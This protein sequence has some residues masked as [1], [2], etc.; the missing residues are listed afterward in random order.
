[1]CRPYA[2][3]AAAL[4]LFAWNPACMGSMQ[5]LTAVC[6]D[7]FADYDGTNKSA[8]FAV[9]PRGLYW[10]RLI[11]LTPVERS[12]S[13]KRL[14][15][16]AIYKDVSGGDLCLKLT[17]AQQPAVAPKEPHTLIQG[18]G[19]KC[20]FTERVVKPAGKRRQLRIPL[21]TQ[22]SMIVEMQ[23]AGE[24]GGK[25][26]SIGEVIRGLEKDI[27]IEHIQ[28]VVTNEPAR[29][30]AALTL[31]A[32]DRVPLG[33]SPTFIATWLGKPINGVDESGDKA[34][35][36]STYK[37]ND[38]SLAILHIGNLPA[39]IIRTATASS[40]GAGGRRFEEKAPAS[41]PNIF[42]SLRPSYMQTFEAPMV[43]GDNW[44]QSVEYMFVG[45][46]SDHFRLTL[47]KGRQPELRPQA[48]ME[49]LIDLGGGRFC[50]IE[51]LDGEAHPS[52][53]EHMLSRVRGYA[54]ELDQPPRTGRAST[55]EM[56]KQ[57]TPDM[58]QYKIE[59]WVGR[60]DK[61][62]VK[63][64]Q[65]QNIYYLDN[66]TSAVLARGLMSKEVVP[67]GEAERR[68]RELSGR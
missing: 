24:S 45:G 56:F 47:G 21:G 65:R 29:L 15:Q 42:P 34:G 49:K 41:W 37:L 19:R 17:V 32:I 63:A 14:S 7:D 28:S 60:P 20:F 62:F 9:F 40:A 6:E 51:R 55:V 67:K 38:G 2:T 23:D 33:T 43:D 5:D 50:R 26:H 54:A 46:S 58:S 53:M 1:M 8:W 61:T 4:L 25:V 39:R 18:F 44:S 57:I 30:G 11:A 12:S 13:G 48:R 35:Y 64:G 59:S 31:D 22:W 68:A 36:A 16:S 10:H 66:S 52:V 3:I 27:D